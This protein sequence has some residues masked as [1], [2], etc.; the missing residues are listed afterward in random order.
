M[1][2]VK[3]GSGSLVIAIILGI[4][5]IVMFIS[6]VLQSNTNLESAD[7]GSGGADISSFLK[8]QSQLEVVKKESLIMERKLVDMANK[9]A[10]KSTESAVISQ[11][12]VPMNEV[13]SR[14]TRP[15]VI[16]LGMHRSGV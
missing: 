15:G 13:E 4:G 7:S 2:D 9:L 11:A 14:V 8:I 5:Y 16:I 12:I 3:L 10:Q 1:V 6:V